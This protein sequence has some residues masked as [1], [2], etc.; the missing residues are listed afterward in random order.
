MRAVMPPSSSPPAAAGPSVGGAVDGSKDGTLVGAGDGKG[1]AVGAVAGSALRIVPLRD[2]AGGGCTRVR[3]GGSLVL[4][5]EL[6]D[7][8]PNEAGCSSCWRFPRGF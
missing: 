7:G 6:I 2:T 1:N 3:G 5:V 4:R 8:M